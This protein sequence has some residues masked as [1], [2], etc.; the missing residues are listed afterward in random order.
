MKRAVLVALLAAAVA[1]LCALAVLAARPG[2]R[3]EVY[4]VLARPGE[5][6][7]SPPRACG[8]GGW[9]RSLVELGSPALPVVLRRADEEARVD[10]PPLFRLI[11][12]VMLGAEAGRGDQGARERY[13]ALHAAFLRSRHAE[14]RGLALLDHEFRG[15]PRIVAAL[16]GHLRRLVGTSA[17]DPGEVDAARNALETIAQAL[18]PGRPAGPAWPPGGTAAEI[19]GAAERW[20]EENRARLPPQIE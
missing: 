17:P 20:L 1:C 19:A 8:Y 14:L 12:A 11:A 3:A 2:V 5:V 10:G 7:L 6:T 15:D 13:L 18:D 16:V 4:A 9:S